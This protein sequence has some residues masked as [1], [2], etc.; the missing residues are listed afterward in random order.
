MRLDEATLEIVQ[1]SVLQRSSMKIK[2]KN[3]CQTSFTTVMNF[4]VLGHAC[5]GI[6][7][8]LPL[9]SLFAFALLCLGEGEVKAKA[10]L[11]FWQSEVKQS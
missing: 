2:K 5:E 9:P 6:S 10:K 7:K 8:G 1:F 3:L 11:C 4:L